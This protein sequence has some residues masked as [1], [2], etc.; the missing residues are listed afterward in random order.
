MKNN[1]QIISDELL[2]AYLDGNASKEEILQVL[3]A[4]GDDTRLQEVLDIATMIDEDLKPET[5]LLP[6]MQ[7]SAESG[8]NICSVLCEAYV[9]QRRGISFDEKELLA[10]ARQHQWLTPQGAPLHV[11]GQLI[12]HQGLMVTRRYD[13]S[14]DDI[15][16]ALALDNDVLVAVDSDKLYPERPDPDDAPNH[17]LVV[18]GIDKDCVT[19]YEPQSNSNF[20]F[21]I[22]KRLGASRTTIWY[23]CFRLLATTSR[24]LSTWLTSNS[25]TT[26]RNSVGPLP[27]MPTRYGRRQG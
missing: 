26:C 13:A 21:R 5:S 7:L 2:A 12:A 27:R 10:T 19:I 20:E 25:P 22:L 9:L 24:S 15:R 11:I 1:N 16:H 14:L 18:I 23:V 6:M 3:A 4:L 17:A 8:E